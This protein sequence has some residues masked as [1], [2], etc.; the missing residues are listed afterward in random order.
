MTGAH[1]ESPEATAGLRRKR[2]SSIRPRKEAVPNSM[3]AGRHLT[4]VQD[5][6]SARI[7]E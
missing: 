4:L 3:P 7:R 6:R 2:S 5:E 1:G